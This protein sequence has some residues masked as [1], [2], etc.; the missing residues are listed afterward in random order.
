MVAQRF[1]SELMRGAGCAAPMLAVFA[2]LM[3]PGFWLR[4]DQF[5]WEMIND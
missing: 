1:C 3:I 4:F 5:P 2:L